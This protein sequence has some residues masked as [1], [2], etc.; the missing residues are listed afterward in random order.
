MSGGGNPNHDPKNGEFTS[1]PTGRLDHGVLNVPLSKRG[2]IDAQIDRFKAKVASD[3]R[4]HTKIKS[5]ETKIFR[6]QAKSLVA[7]LPDSSLDSIAKKSGTTAA[8]VK[9]NLMSN[10][11]FDPSRIIKILGPK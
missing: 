11:H 3:L 8:Q 6:E 7:S 2:N 1:G 10:A 4:A 9:K 5:E